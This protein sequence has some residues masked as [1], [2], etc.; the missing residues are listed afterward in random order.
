MDHYK[1]PEKSKS[2]L[3]DFIDLE[4][5]YLI[6]NNRRFLVNVNLIKI[7]D[8]FGAINKVVW[9]IDHVQTLLMSFPSSLVTSWTVVMVDPDDLTADALWLLLNEHWVTILM[10]VVDPDVGIDATVPSQVFWRPASRT[11]ET[12]C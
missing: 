10:L 6:T 7:Q 5:L 3:N 11:G 1:T 8:V 12:F 9:V 2:L 4:P